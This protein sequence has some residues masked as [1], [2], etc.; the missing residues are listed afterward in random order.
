[1]TLRVVVLISGRGSNL[2]ALID[3]Q[4]SGAYTIVA[5]VSNNPAAAG[6]QLSAQAGIAATAI[7]HQDYARRE[8][9]DCDLTKTIDRWRPEL[10]VL[11]GFMRVLG[12]GFVSHY[13]GRLINIHPSLLPE[14]PGLNTHERVLQAAVQWHGASV[15]YVSDQLDAG[16]VI[17]QTRVAVRADD[18]AQSLAKRVLAGEH[19]LLTAT[20]ASIASGSVGIKDGKVI[21]DGKYLQTPLLFD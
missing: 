19:Q 7:A 17:S 3:A 12:Q 13:A 15:H 18:D 2:Q 6:L 21:S 16:P 8:D 10:I 4:Q 1:M 14:F 11:A 9:F 5:V 20:V